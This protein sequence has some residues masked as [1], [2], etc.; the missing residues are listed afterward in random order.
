MLST[1][2]AR[3][4]CYTVRI[5]RSQSYIQFTYNFDGR[6]ICFGLATSDLLFEAPD[7]ASAT[8]PSAC[9]VERVGS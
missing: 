5:M 1:S 3:R 2:P 7:R 4:E 6:V 9:C 8:V